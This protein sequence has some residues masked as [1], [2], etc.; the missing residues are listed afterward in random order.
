M[1]RSA[2]PQVEST[3][4]VDA[5]PAAEPRATIPGLEYERFFTREGVDPF[6]EIEWD[7]RSAVIGN[8]KGNVVFEQRDVEIP[9]FWSQ[10]A[11][12]IVVSKYFRG[13]IGTPDRERSVKQLV[14]RVV[15]TITGWAAK[16][17]YFAS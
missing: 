8:E 13:T 1:Q 17:K 16:Q 11:T 7:I 5:R 4:Q 3:S 14:G 9:K 2:A 6:D 15:D 12:N 10:Q